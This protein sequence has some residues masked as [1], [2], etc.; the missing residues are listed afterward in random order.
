MINRFTRTDEYVVYDTFNTGFFMTKVSERQRKIETI[1]QEYVN[2]WC[3]SE[4]STFPNYI[5]PDVTIHGS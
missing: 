5:F 3:G 4:I 2:I 1:K